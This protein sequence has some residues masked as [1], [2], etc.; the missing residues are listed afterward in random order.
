MKDSLN[1][2]IYKPY[3]NRYC[4]RL[5]GKIVHT[6]SSQGLLLFTVLYMYNKRA[7]QEN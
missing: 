7:S 2:T 1:V 5:E 4:C 3:H 6:Q